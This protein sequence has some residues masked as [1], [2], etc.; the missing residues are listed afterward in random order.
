MTIIKLTEYQPDKIPRYQIP[1]SV[2]DELQQ[3]YSNQVTVNLEYSKTGDYWQLTSQGWVGYIP[4]TNELSIQLQPKVPLNNL[5]GMLDYAY[6]LRSFHILEGLIDCKSVEEFYD[7][8][9]SILI[10][11]IR[12]RIRQGLYRT[13]IPTTGQLAYLRGRL[14]VQQTIQKP[15]DIKLNCHYDEHT[16]DIEDNQIIA[17]TL[18]CIS[19][20]GLYS[21]KVSP[22]LRQAYHALQNLVTLQP[23]SARDCIGR[24]YNRLNQNYQRLHALC[25]FFLEHSGPSHQTGSNTMLP[26]LVN[27]AK[28]YERFVAEWLKSHLPTGFGIKIL[29]RVDIDKTLYFYI[30]L[31]LY[32]IATEKTCCILDTKY[33]IPISP[34]R[35]DFNQVVIYA[36]TQDCQEA[37]LVYPAP[38]TQPLDVK[39]RDIRV[40]SLTFSLDGN[41]EEAGELFLK[42][43][44]GLTQK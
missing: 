34:S 15:W 11:G 39:I 12:D 30:D 25:R 44:T 27:M 32:E 42:K 17:W 31:V 28:L 10:N 20:T 4:L 21:A 37:V 5:F 22:M 9:V 19:R 26:F 13:Y 8:L 35:D 38:L 43:L 40:R 24:N 6:N 2:I 16:S 36:I 3:K 14:D 7:Y 1:E 33:K 23:Y 29:E 18:H 41:L